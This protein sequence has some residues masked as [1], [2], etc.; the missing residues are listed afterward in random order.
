MP[1]LIRN[2][3]DEITKQLKSIYPSVDIK[4]EWSAFRNERRLYSPRIDVAVGPF[5][6]EHGN[7]CTKKYNS[8]MESSKSF[9]EMLLLFHQDNIKDNSIGDSQ[10]YQPKT[11]DELM[12]FNKNARCLLAIEVENKGSRKHLLGSAVNAAALGRLGIVVGW[13]QEN[14]KALVKLQAYWE[15]LR[16]VDKNTYN[17]KNLIILSPDQLRKA[18][19]AS[20]HR[21]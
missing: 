9:I 14:V 8:L 16:S 12:K 6:I 21:R 2:F 1:S 11:F 20:R 10:L 18:I 19:S 17:T 7:S 13:A 15:Y 5:S 4:T 3:Q